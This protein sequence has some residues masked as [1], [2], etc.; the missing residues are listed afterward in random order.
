MKKIII[1]V[2]MI[3][4]FLVLV[5]IPEYKELNH[6]ILVNK[7]KIICT[8]NN[9]NGTIFEIIPIK[10]DNGVKYKEKKYYTKGESLEELKINLEKQTNNKFY[11]KSI[12]IIKT[13]CNRKEI[14]KTFHI[15]NP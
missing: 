9:I 15:K 10:E 4:I 2:F 7:I 14:E 8:N 11:Y 1:Q 12:K 13:N 6:L 3:S 5:P